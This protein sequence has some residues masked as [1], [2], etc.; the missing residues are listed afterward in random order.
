MEP[1]AVDI[2]T[3]GAAQI[4]DMQDVVVGIVSERDVEAGDPQ[5][6]RSLHQELSA[7]I[8]QYLVPRIN[9]A[10][11]LTTYRLDLLSRGKRSYH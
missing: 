3:V 5:I 10:A 1:L 11:T 6:I 4:I 8:A 2:G 7:R 9:C